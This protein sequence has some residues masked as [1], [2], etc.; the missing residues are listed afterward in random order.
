MRT[1]PF[2]SLLALSVGLAGCGNGEEPEEAKQAEAE[3]AAPAEE[4]APAAPAE[5]AAEEAIE[6]IAVVH[7]SSKEPYGAYLTDQLGMALYMFTADTQ[8]EASACYG[9]CEGAWP[10]Y[11]TTG[12][13]EAGAEAVQ[14]DLLGTLTRDDGLVQVTYNGWPL[15][16]FIR[17]D[18]AG[19][20]NGQDI[21]AFGGEWYLV[22]PAGEPIHTEPPAEGGE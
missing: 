9:E 21:E 1:I 3:Q 6:N 22:A 4:A 10:P 12:A 16:Y 19:A 13:P 11:F 15:Y 2:V 5:P 17:D 20:T 7:A 18:A 14:A 8:G